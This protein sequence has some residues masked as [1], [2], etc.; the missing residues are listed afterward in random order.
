MGPAGPVREQS[1]SYHAQR[2]DLWCVKSRQDPGLSS[3][4]GG[5]LDLYA[6]GA[7][8]LGRSGVRNH[9]HASYPRLVGCI[10]PLYRKL[11]GFREFNAG[12]GTEL[13][14][15]LFPSVMPEDTSG[16]GGL[17]SLFFRRGIGGCLFADLRVSWLPGS[18]SRE[19]RDALSHEGVAYAPHS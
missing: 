4:C 19:Y 17:Q 16:G 12:R 11:P 14:K 7:L 13:S 18:D 6:S 8:P 1:G 5:L 3:S 10:R 9:D 2:L 15:R